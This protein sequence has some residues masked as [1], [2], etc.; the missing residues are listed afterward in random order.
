MILRKIQKISDSEM[1][2]MKI[3]WAN[4]GCVESALLKKELGEVKGWKPNTILTFLARLIEKNVITAE[5]RGKGKAS[6]YIALLSE[7][8][9][10]RY[11]TKEFLETVYEG[12][13]KSFITTLYDGG[14]LNKEEIEKL[15]KWFSER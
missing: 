12:S 2:V 11:E 7:S 10:K 3:I 8:E 6:K 5:K 1:E 9:Y 13:I 14:D 15:K 4:N